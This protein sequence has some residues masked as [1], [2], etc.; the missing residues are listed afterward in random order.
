MTKKQ[1]ANTTRVGDPKVAAVFASCSPKMR[2]RLLRLR[3]LILDTAANT[4]G[5][6]KLEETLKWNEPAYLTTQS[7]SGSTIRINRLPDNKHYAMFFNCN[8][9]L[10]DT[11]RTLFPGAFRYQGNR[12]IVFSIDEDIAEKELQIC[13]A[14]AL[15]YHR[16]KN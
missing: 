7:K 3:K 16:K 2:Q 6:G 13:V 1:T 5:V 8:T 11:F 10:V 12:S 14:M 9:S 15:T 4:P